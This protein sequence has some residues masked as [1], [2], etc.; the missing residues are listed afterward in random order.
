MSQKSPDPSSL[1]GRLQRFIKSL[2]R[3]P[4]KRRPPLRPPKNRLD[5]LW[6]ALRQRLDCLQTFCQ[7]APAIVWLRKQ[8]RNP[9]NRARD[10]NGLLIFVWVLLIAAYFLPIPF[11]RGLDTF[12]GD[13]SVRELGFTYT[14]GPTYSD[15]ALMAGIQDLR[16]ID[17]QGQQPEPIALLGRFSSPNDATL[18][19]QLDDLA[20]APGDSLDLR[21]EFPAPSSQLVATPAPAAPAPA[22]PA[23]ETAL[24]PSLPALTRLDI[25]P[26]SRV[27]TLAYDPARQA[28]APATLSLCLQD[29]DRAAESPDSDPFELDT[30]DRCT[31]SA[32]LLEPLAR[33]RLQ[34]IGKAD[35]LWGDRPLELVLTHV[36]LPDLDRPADPSEG[37]VL[38]Y[39]PENSSSNLRLFSPTRLKLQ[40]PDLPANRD[41]DTDLLPLWLGFGFDVEAVTFTRTIETGLPS[42]GRTISSILGGRLRLRDRDLEVTKNQFLT[43][44]R[45]AQS[46]DSPCID[47]L[48]SLTLEPDESQGI[49]TFFNGRSRTLSVGLRPSLPV[50]TLRSRNWLARALPPEGFGALV[51]FLSAVIAFRIPLSFMFHNAA[52]RPNP[53]SPTDPPRSSRPDSRRR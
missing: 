26:E 10:I 8:I 53:L 23:A 49:R 44:A 2:E 11:L 38:R 22:A 4:R 6:A 35:L 42:E 12:E 46:Y 7:R 13:L 45:N 52:T 19:A 32:N 9:N 34:E 39:E 15:R 41:P 48:H 27:Q 51:A 18:Q 33:D 40:L 20:P 28:N 16:Q 29:R 17:L 1:I 24:P 14:G 37:I 25:A 43:C 21:L 5:P 47:Y 31:Q 30:G 3:P 36:G 50:E